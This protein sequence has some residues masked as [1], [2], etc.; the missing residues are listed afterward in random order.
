M[1]TV[2]GRYC[3]EV[4]AFIVRV[5]ALK[6]SQIH[7]FLCMDTAASWMQCDLLL[8]AG[9]PCGRMTLLVCQ[10]YLRVFAKDS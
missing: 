3:K 8:D 5:L 6:H 9:V 1:W 2:P 7:S 10:I 4:A